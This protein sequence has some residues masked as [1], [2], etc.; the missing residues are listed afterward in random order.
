LGCEYL[1][2]E[3]LWSAYT[4]LFLLQMEEIT[5][6][7]LL[8]T[9]YYSETKRLA[10]NSNNMSVVSPVSTI[11]QLGPLHQLP[12]LH[13]HFRLLS[14]PNLHLSRFSWLLKIASHLSL[15]VSYSSGFFVTGGLDG[16]A[17]TF[18]VHRTYIL[19]AFFIFYPIKS[20]FTLKSRFTTYESV[21]C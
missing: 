4:E 12:F 10:Q 21:T 11:K 6:R 13:L 1:C 15:F 8:E 9:A 20:Y 14:H 5:V 18:V 17:G 19:L 16:L 7:S 2:A 3:H